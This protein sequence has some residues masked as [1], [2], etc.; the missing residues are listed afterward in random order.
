MPIYAPSR[1]HNLLTLKKNLL[2]STEI[3]SSSLLQNSSLHSKLHCIATM[4]IS[5]LPLATTVLD[6]L[7]ISGYLSHDDRNN[8]ALLAE[9]VTLVR[10]SKMSAI[11]QYF[12][13]ENPTSK[14]AMCTVC[15]A[16]VSRGGTSV[17]HWKRRILPLNGSFGATVQFDR[18]QIHLWNCP[19]P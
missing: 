8:S 14:T 16:S 4:D 15:K 19:K 12:T 1:Y 5:W 17:G 11:W 6:C 9:S 7:L 13:L 18:F 10:A 2:V 3:N